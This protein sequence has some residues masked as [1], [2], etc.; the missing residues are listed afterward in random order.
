[1]VGTWTYD[2]TNNIITVTGG[3]AGA[4]AT[5]L[6]CWN[7]DKA[8]T[9]LIVT[10]RN[11]NGADGAPVA[12]TRALRPTDLYVLGGAKLYITITNFTA[13]GTIHIVGT[14]ANGGALSEDIAFTGNATYNTVGFYHTVT[15]TQVTVFAGNFTYT[16]TQAQWGVVWKQGTYQYMLECRLILGDGSTTTYFIDL[17][18]EVNFQNAISASY[19]K[20]ISILNKATL[21]LGQLDDVSTKATSH[22]CTIVSNLNYYPMVIDSGN[23]GAVINLYSCTIICLTKYGY[24]GNTVNTPCKIYN[25]ILD[26]VDLYHNL[27][28]DLYNVLSVNAPYALDDCGGTGDKITITKASVAVLLYGGTSVTLT[29]ITISGATTVT[30]QMGNAITTDKYVVNSTIDAWT[31]NWG[32]YVHTAKV[33]RQYKFDLKVYDSAGAAISGATVT[34]KN[35]D[36]SNAFSVN[37]V[38]DGSIVQQTVS[39]G[40]YD[41]AN[42]NTLQ[43]YGP[44]TLIISKVGYMT[45]THN[46]LV[47]DAAVNRQIYLRTQLAGTADVGE[48]VSGLKFYKDDADSILTGTLALTGT[49]T[50]GDVADGKTFY[51]NDAK[52]LRMGAHKEQMMFPPK[53]IVKK[54]YVDKMELPSLALLTLYLTS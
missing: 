17:N 25:C 30:F 6:D 29:N 20:L 40:Y 51:G 50:E 46:L 53:P 27:A 42:G 33:L 16:F 47:I 1:M 38:A 39:R 44:F 34:L 2:A 11:I 7:A 36:A 23:A 12:V 18:K 32:A 9:L 35:A 13:N 24:L 8:G 48:V 26:Y 3:T 19:Q 14:D 37:T 15:S 54:V 10:A 31:F 43:D 5:F 22:G 41:K 52:T 28:W 45:Y 21:T 49:A 4:P